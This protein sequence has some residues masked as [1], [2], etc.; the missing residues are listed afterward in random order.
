MAHPPPRLKLISLTGL[1]RQFD[2]RIPLR[3]EERV[4]VLHGKNGVGK[5]V[6]LRLLSALMRGDYSVLAEVPFAEL[7]LDFEDR[8][9]VAVTQEAIS[10]Q[11]R[12][13]RR[14]KRWARLPGGTESPMLGLE[15][16]LDGG[17][18]VFAWTEPD[19]LRDFL[20]A[21]PVLFIDVERLFV[22]TA[23]EPGPSANEPTSTSAMRGIAVDMASRI[24]AADSAYRATSTRLDDSL[25]ARLF[26]PRTNGASISRKDLQIRTAALETER[27]RLR[28]IG[29]VDDISPF[30][31]S[32]LT[33]AQRA[34]FAVYLADNEE[35]LTVF[36]SLADRAEI[37]LGVLNRKLAPK[38]IRLDKDGGYLVKSHDGRPLEL[39]LLSS[40]EQHELLL[41]HTLLFRT[42]PGALVLIDEPELS[43]HV[44]WQTEVLAELLQIARIVPFDAIVAT[45]SPYIVGEHR[46]LMVRLGEPS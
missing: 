34:M 21:I 17:K 38:S 24:R 30:N 20:R 13:K 40:G 44:T 46:E 3:T 45:H 18:P 28:E 15:Y 12:R 41:L 19:V 42:D 33:D 14:N 32:S 29:L 9:F 23:G 7:R 10:S 22:R 16:S 6:T 36:K 43:L 35:K 26:A 25:P 39:D 2:H 8:S 11:E 37:L 5:T 31:P 1:F 27:R 4:T